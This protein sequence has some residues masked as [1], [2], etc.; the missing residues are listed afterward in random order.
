[1]MEVLE[2]LRGENWLHHY[3]TDDNSLKKQI[4]SD[5]LK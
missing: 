3:G 5:P 2:A 1:M 4:D